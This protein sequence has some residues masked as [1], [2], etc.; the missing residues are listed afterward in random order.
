[1]PRENTPGRP[2]KSTRA[3]VT[4]TRK[5][6]PSA[7]DAKALEESCLRTLRRSADEARNFHFELTHGAISLVKYPRAS[8]GWL[9]SCC[10][11]VEEFGEK[12]FRLG[13]G[14]RD[15]IAAIEKS[16]PSFTLEFRRLVAIVRDILKIVGE[17]A[18]TLSENEWPKPEEISA[19]IQAGE[20]IF[21]REFDLSK[22]IAVAKPVDVGEGRG[23][24]V[25]VKLP[26]KKRDFSRYASLMD[27]LTEPQHK[28]MLLRLEQG[29]SFGAIASYLQISK[30]TA[31]Q[32]YAAAT[33]KM[34][35]AHAQEKGAEK[36]AKYDPEKL[37]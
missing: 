13:Y 24:V 8:D 1:V 29:M 28:V 16:W 12:L 18:N 7:S 21:L 35:Q 9:Y 20:S 27:T 26:T 33:R 17:S 10:D 37:G 30:S 4:G 6:R 34:Q 5:E 31:H 14:R 22:R 19:G 3:K 23:Q 15:V 36:R 25:S 2:R 11:A 32:H